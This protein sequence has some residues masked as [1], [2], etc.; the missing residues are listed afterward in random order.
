M[1]YRPQKKLPTKYSES[2]H[3]YSEATSKL[4]EANSK[5]TFN[6]CSPE[7]DRKRVEDISDDIQVPGK[8]PINY[9]ESFE[10]SRET[11][12]DYSTLETS[13]TSANNIAE[14]I[15]IR[16][17]IPNNYSKPFRAYSEAPFDY[18]TI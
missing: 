13:Q 3:A 14:Y 8:I 10:A 1:I 4:F 16:K 6:Y 5:T 11:T 7:I 17:K 12:F 15:S 9:S 18:S 2:C